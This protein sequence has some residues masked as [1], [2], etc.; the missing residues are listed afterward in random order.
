MPVKPLTYADSGVDIERGNRLVERIKIAAR[1]TA[2]D[3]LVAG[4]GG[5]GSLFELP[6]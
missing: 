3:G 2:R 5:F 1:S 4:I 6:V